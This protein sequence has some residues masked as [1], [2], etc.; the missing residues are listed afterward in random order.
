MRMDLILFTSVSCMGDKIEDLERVLHDSKFKMSRGHF[1][2]KYCMKEYIM[3]NILKEY[4]WVSFVLP[5]TRDNFHDKTF[6]DDV[7]LQTW[8]KKQTMNFKVLLTW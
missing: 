8:A 1:K 3:W 6:A 7:E 5:Y 4:F 2:N